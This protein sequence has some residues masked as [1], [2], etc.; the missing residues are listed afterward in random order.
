MSIGDDGDWVQLEEGNDFNDPYKFRLCSQWVYVSALCFS[1]QSNELNRDFHIGTSDSNE[2]HCERQISLWFTCFSHCLK[3]PGAKSKELQI[4]FRF[5]V[6]ERTTFK[7]QVIER[8][9]PIRILAN[10]GRDCKEIALR[11]SN[12]TPSFPWASTWNTLS[13]FTPASMPGMI[14]PTAI[15]SAVDDEAFNTKLTE[16]EKA[17][18]CEGKILKELK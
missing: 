7:E 2:R 17:A 12:R 3:M 1:H 14:S 8:L 18:F 6:R 16:D 9:F 13:T 4:R 11:P 5:K 15:L 10:P